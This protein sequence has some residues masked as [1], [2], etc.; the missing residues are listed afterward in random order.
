[1][2]GHCRNAVVEDD[3]YEAHAVVDGI[4]KSGHARVVEG[5]IPYYGNRSSRVLRVH[6]AK[7]LLESD[8][9]RDAGTHA[10]AGIRCCERRQRPKV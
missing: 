6:D 8:T 9:R 3:G 4:E 5:R 7:G 1:M 2:P 10:Y